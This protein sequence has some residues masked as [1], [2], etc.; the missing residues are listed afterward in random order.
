[1]ATTSLNSHF[2]ARKLHSLLGLLPVGAFLV[3]HL[4]EN[5]Q[6]RHGMEAY[7]KMA[8]GIN[9]LN[10]RLVLEIGLIAIPLFL[11]AAY[12]LVIWWQGESNTSN[13][14]YFRN[15]MYRLQRLTSWLALIFILSH[16]W[17]T[18]IVAATN[19]EV[20][21]NLFRHM[22]TQLSDPLMF[23][24]YAIGVTASTF[25]LANGLWLMGITWGVTIG[26]RSQKISGALC[27]GLFVLLTAI[28][29]HG[30][31]GFHLL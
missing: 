31:L 21:G 29:V 13:Y 6:S 19:S 18:R 24:W 7:N 16:V 11:H 1:M 4:W 20:A 23:G 10:Y 26:P 27:M 5:S 9:N 8:Q 30:L 2:L 25:H 28:G 3:F 22:Q 12:G 14:G 15:W 17:S